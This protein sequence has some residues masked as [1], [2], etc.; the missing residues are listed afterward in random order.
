MTVEGQGPGIA[1]SGVGIERVVVT[2]FELGLMF[3]V[4]GEKGRARL[5]TRLAG[6]GC[7]T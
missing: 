5:E 6:Y 2:G 4:V 3:R 7:L 1:T